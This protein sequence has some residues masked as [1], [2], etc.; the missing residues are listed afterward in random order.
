M[1]EL[2]LTKVF[3]NSSHFIILFNL[4]KIEKYI[5]DTLFKYKILPAMNITHE[6]VIIKLVDL[7]IQDF[8]NY[9]SVG[10]ITMTSANALLSQCYQVDPYDDYTPLKPT[11][12]ASADSIKIKQCRDVNAGLAGSILLAYSYH[13]TLVLSP[14]NFWIHITQQVGKHILKNSEKYRDLFFEHKGK[15]EIIVKIDDAMMLYGMNDS[16]TWEYGIEQI[17]NQINNLVKDDAVNTFV[18]T[19]S[20]TTTQSLIANKIILMDAMKNYFTYSMETMCGITNIEMTGTF[21][22]WKKLIVNSEKLCELVS[23]EDAGTA[24]RRWFKNNMYPILN[25]LLD[26]YIGKDT[27]DWWSHVVDEETKFG[28][29]QGTKYYGWI[30]NLFLYNGAGQLYT[31]DMR[32]LEDFPSGVS[33]CPFVFV[34]GVTNCSTKLNL[35]SGNCGSEIRESDGAVIPHISWAVITDLSV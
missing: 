24:V 2:L 20:T 18:R 29:G 21:D 11:L 10:E 1:I 26:T 3:G 31:R 27:R 33:I 30:T 9:S 17:T 8:N 16:R 23:R 5:I 7:P 32:V 35:V 15:K 6:R 14:D 13:R 22:D 34:N 12:I 4:K 28:S 25:N 19:Y